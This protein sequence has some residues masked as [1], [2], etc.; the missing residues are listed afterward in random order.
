MCVSVY[1]SVSVC[2]HAVNAC[3]EAWSMGL[4]VFMKFCKVD[5]GQFDLQSSTYLETRA[6]ED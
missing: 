6:G 3:V 1:V 4:C 5:E 2:V